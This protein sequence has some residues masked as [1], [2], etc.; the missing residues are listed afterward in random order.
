[1]KL[2][3]KQIGLLLLIVMM[4]VAFTACDQAVLSDSNSN[5]SFLES[6]SN[7]PFF[8]FQSGAVRDTTSEERSSSSIVN[9]QVGP[10]VSLT[11]DSINF[12]YELR[13]GPEAS[14]PG[15]FSDVTPNPPVVRRDTASG[16]AVETDTLEVQVGGGSLTRESRLVTVSLTSVT[17][18]DGSEILL[19][20]NGD[21]QIGRNRTIR[22]EPSIFVRTLGAGGVNSNA[23]IFEVSFD[24]TAV[25]ASNT[26][27]PSP[28]LANGSVEPT[29]VDNFSITGPDADAFSFGGI[30]GVVQPLGPSATL[31]TSF[32]ADIGVLNVAFQPDSPGEKS[33]TLEFDMQNSVDNTTVS[34]S[35][36][37]VAESA[38]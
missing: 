20:R 21:E 25:G 37:G 29:A 28:V 30:G 15:D 6:S 23:N 5:N 38:E 14:S 18:S 24:T 17:A 27:S 36:S 13:P 31:G 34:L 9:F 3:L 4:A 1:M 10:N 22:I 19:G 2:V 26:P 35:L 32:P 33:A 7:T 16:S 11:A 8:E 12:E